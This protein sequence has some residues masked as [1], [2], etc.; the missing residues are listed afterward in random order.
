MLETGEKDGTILVV[1]ELPLVVTLN[2]PD[3]ATEL[4]QHPCE[5][6]RYDG[7]GVRLTTERKSPKLVREV[8]KDDQIVLG[9]TMCSK[10]YTIRFKDRVELGSVPIS[11]HFWTKIYLGPYHFVKKHLDHDPLPPL[12][13]TGNQKCSVS[14]MSKGHC[15]RDQKGDLCG[16]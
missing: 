9:V 14:G 2:I 15:G 8:I 3:S 11:I 12:D 13:S 16:T 6:V 4:S 5:K 10:F 1:I 7:E